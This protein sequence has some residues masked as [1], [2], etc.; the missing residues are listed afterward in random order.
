M[1]EALTPHV[2]RQDYVKRYLRNLHQQEANHNFVL[3]ANTTFQ[4]TGETLGTALDQSKTMLHTPIRQLQPLCA[5]K[6]DPVVRDAATA[7][8]ALSHEELAFAY[9]AAD[10][11]LQSI[12]QGYVRGSIKMEPLLFKGFIAGQLAKANQKTQGYIDPSEARGPDELGHENH[13][14]RDAQAGGADSVHSDDYESADEL[15]GDEEDYRLYVEFIRQLKKDI[16]NAKSERQL[17]TLEQLLKNQIQPNTPD[18]KQIIN[19][20]DEV[21]KGF[22]GGRG[23]KKKRCAIIKGRGLLHPVGNVHW[24]DVKQ[25]Q[26]G[27]VNVKN[28]KFKQ[29]GKK[30]RVGGKLAS[31][32]KSVL[33]GQNPRYD[34]IEELNDQERS[35]L[36][37]L[38]KLTGEDRF[39][40]KLKDKTQDEKDLHDFE[41][42]KG[43]IIAGNDSFE[44][45]HDFKKL[46]LSLMAKHRIH[47][48]EG[49]DI[50]LE[51]A[52]LGY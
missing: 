36:N 2:T 15:S 20:I 3:E 11:L 14:Y 5:M 49:T 42:M 22:F 48:K 41:V 21:R 46:L 40:V 34:D 18:Y 24:I 28:D 32:V 39:H 16:S 23:L 52:T 45:I 51:L 8:Q 37:K 31:A 9:Q 13:H 50:L 47:K 29:I 27:Y 17:N 10:M 6:Y 7:V 30:E 35:Y 1:S 38:G 26:E 12:R 4:S 43:E 44:L 19:Q 25:L 33:E